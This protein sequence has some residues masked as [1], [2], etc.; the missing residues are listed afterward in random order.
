MVM[1]A[2]KS[3]HRYVVGYNNNFAILP[4]GKTVVGVNSADLR[5]LQAEN[6]TSEQ[7]NCKAFNTKHLRITT[8]LFNRQQKVLLAGDIKGHIIAFKKPS[9]KLAWKKQKLNFGPAS[10]RLVHFTRLDSAEILDYD[11]IGSLCVLAGKSLVL[12]DMAANKVFRKRGR[13][14]AIGDIKSVQICRRGDKLVLAVCGSSPDYSEGRSNFFDISRIVSE[15]NIRELWGLQVRG[16]ASSNAAGLDAAAAAQVAEG[17][18]T[19][20]EHKL[21]AEDLQIE[22]L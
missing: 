2:H 17:A 14:L 15:T 6:I 8:V 12:I 18:E 3:K 4:D 11:Q 22:V 13:D 16:M 1:P 9:K 10:Q 21:A 5:Y 20:A 19:A 7:P